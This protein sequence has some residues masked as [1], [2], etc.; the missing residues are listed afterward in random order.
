[1]NTPTPLPKDDAIPFYQEVGNE[2]ALFEYAFNNQLPLLIKGPTGCGKT[3]FISHMAKRL[4]RP[5]FTVACH[6]DLTASDLVGRHL[7]GE[8]AT[9]WNDG[10]LTSAVRSGGIC[11]LDEVVEARKDTTVVL[12]PLADD[13]RILPIDRTGEVLKAPPGFMLVVSYNPGYQNFLK[14]MKPS[15]RQRFI[16]MRFQFPKPEIEQKIVIQESGIDKHMASRLM[17]LAVA[18]RALNGHDLEESVSTRLLIYTA[19]LV[20]DGFSPTE[21]CRAAMVETL[22]DDLEIVQALMEVVYATFGE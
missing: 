16:S 4:G 15:T 22:T 13:R 3:R 14:G 6:D 9:Y 17:A 7:I 12:H 10:P 19:K 5:L 1:M 8:N 18:L 2:V 11:Y 20:K 21:A